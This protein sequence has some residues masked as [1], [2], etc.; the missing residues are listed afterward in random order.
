[1]KMEKTITK[2]GDTEIEKL[3]FHQNKIPVLEKI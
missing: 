1:M 3:K 2:F